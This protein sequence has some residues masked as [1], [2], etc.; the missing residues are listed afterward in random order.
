MKRLT[1][2]GNLGR[3]PELRDDQSGGQYA[4]FSV[5]VNVGSRQNPRTDWIEVNCNGKLAEVMANYAKKGAKVL[6][7]GF[8]V[9]NA[10]INKDNEPVGTLKLYANHIELLTRESAKHVTDDEIMIIP[11]TLDTKT[12]KASVGK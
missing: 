4:A 8:P 9:V 7:D 6:V 10:Y 1:I 3:D 2:T 5:A 11:E 12:T